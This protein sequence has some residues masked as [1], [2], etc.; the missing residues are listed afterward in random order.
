MNYLRESTA[1]SSQT[2]FGKGVPASRQA[3][4]RKGLGRNDILNVN[5]LLAIER[6]N[7]VEMMCARNNP[8]Y[9]Q[10]S[11][12]GIALYVLGC[13]DARDLLSVDDLD[14]SDAA[15]I[16][17]ERFVEVDKMDLPPGYKIATDD[18]RF[19]MVLG[20]PVCPVHFAAIVDME[21]ARPFFSKLRYFGSGCDSLEELIEDHLDE[22][23]KSY[24]D[25]HYFRL[26]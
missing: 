21:S 5:S 26:I 7:E 18:R 13:F 4:S 8:I 14:F 17:K 20:D 11:G 2:P 15:A 9:G 25:V 22:G 16:L 19:L 10:I 6:I 12:F 1:V 3:E 24:E 23:I